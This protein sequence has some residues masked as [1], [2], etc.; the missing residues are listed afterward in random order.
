[1]NKNIIQK[2]SLIRAFITILFVFV[3]FYLLSRVVFTY[4][5]KYGATSKTISILFFLA[6]AFVMFHT[7]GYFYSVYRLNRVVQDKTYPPFSGFPKVAILIPAR[8]EPREVLENTLRSARNIGYPEK[9]ICLLDDSSEDKYM[10]EA[11]ELTKE[12]G[13]LLFRRTRRHGAKAGIVNDC[14]K[15]VDAK[16]IAVFDADQN[17]MPDFLSKLLPILESRP[18]L[19]FVQTPQ[20]Y[21]NLKSSRISFAANMQ[22]AVFYEYVCEGKGSTETMMCC[23]T[24]VLLRKKALEEIGGF[25]ESTVTEDFATSLKLHLKGWKSIYYNHVYVFGMGPE[26]LGSYFKQQNRWAQGNVEVFKNVLKELLRHPLKLSPSQWFEYLITGSYYL[27]GWAYLFLILCPMGYIFFNIPSFFANAYIYSFT[28]IPCFVLSISL[29]YISMMGRLYGVKDLGKGQVLSFITLPVYMKASLLGLIGKKST[30]QVTAK[31]GARR[32]PYF[33]LWPQLLI[34]SLGL[35]AIT[36]GLNR[37]YHERTVGMLANTLWTAYHFLLFSGIFYFNEE[38]T[39]TGACKKLKKGV[40]FEYKVLKES[41]S[42]KT[43]EKEAWRDSLIAFSDEKIKPDTL[44]MCK[45]VSRTGDTIIFDGIIISSSEKRSRKGF[46]NEIA[47]TT[48]SED[49]RTKIKE[50]T[51]V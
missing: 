16:Y 12:Y 44:L 15:A 3:I 22:Q 5:A 29:Y 21:T 17:P 9:T 8:H 2:P 6:E 46:K 47:I 49:E 34:W 4:Y 27:I 38:E 28:Y 39:E 19:A 23:G 11:E 35:S 32:I 14:I 43:L 25:D 33:R 13:A 30:F 31:G 48:M 24:N 7:I 26:D 20:F 1:M 50:V 36:W 45:L 42:Y 37:F 51:F 18:E 41:P 10:R 40:I